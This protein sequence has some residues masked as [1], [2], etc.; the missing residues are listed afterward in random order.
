MESMSVG[1]ILK[2]CEGRLVSGNPETKLAGLSTDTRTIKE[3]DMFLA[4]V[5]KK[6]DGHSFI[7]EAFKKKAAG[8]IISCSVKKIPKDRE[9]ICVR[10][11]LRALQRI[12]GHYR[13]KFTLP[14]IAVT[15]SNGKT[16]TKEMLASILSQKFETLRSQASFNNEV[17][18][19]LSLLQISSQHEVC[20]LE[21][22]MNKRGEIRHLAGIAKPDIGVITN[23]GSAHIANFGTLRQI[24]MAKAELLGK[25]SG[26]CVLNA[27]DKH[28]QVLR[29]RCSGK[30][31]TFGLRKEADFRADSIV[32]SASAL[33]F[34]LN[35]KFEVRLPVTGQ[36]NVYNALASIAA[37]S[38]FD[39]AAGNICR[40]LKSLH[41]PPWR[42]E[43]RKCG[44]TEIIND[45]YNA[46]P[47]SM[48]AAI[49]LLAIREGRK[50]LVIADML[51]LGEEAEKCHEDLGR[52]IAQSGI[53]ALFSCGDLARISAQAAVKEGMKEVFPSRTKHELVKKLL[54]ELKPYDIILIKGSR[55]MGMEE[56]AKNVISSLSVSTRVFLWL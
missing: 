56:V 13:D 22:G 42:G 21:I 14:V 16:T 18:V 24:A 25:V 53:D 50:I 37:S 11:T 34:R 54:S 44:T 32:L 6:Y 40:G 17:G 3:G 43:I 29:R 7:M 9:L 30:V 48:R 38:S 45:T 5:G 15:G 35:G 4:I 28:Y 49:S 2:A 19:P 47:D 26:T 52:F 36:H 20:I 23:I 55:A 12:A 8:A 46:N 31:L 10:D 41:L 51:E 39:I 33:S 27:D 1:E